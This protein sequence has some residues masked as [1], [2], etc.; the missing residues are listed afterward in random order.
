MSLT[1]FASYR[2]G[3][4]SVVIDSSNVL[5]SFTVADC[6]Y[7]IYGNIDLKGG[8][9]RIPSGC[10][11]DFQ[12]GSMVNGSVVGRETQMN[13][14][15]GN[16]IG[17]TAEGTWSVEKI[18]DSYFDV[19]QLSDNQIMSN[20]NNLQS[21]KIFNKIYLNKDHYCCSIYKAGG[22]VLDVSSNSKVYL[23][24][25]ISIEGNDLVS[26]KIIRIVN[27]E[28]VQIK[29]GTIV[30]D[31]GLHKY[32]DGSTSQWGHGVLIQNSKRVRIEN[33]IVMKCIGDGFT[34][35]GGSGQHTGDMSQASSDV[36]L[37]HVT[38]KF[39]RRQGLSII[40]AENVV[41]KN[42]VFSDTGTIEFQSPS[43][44]IDIEPN[45]EPHNQTTRN[46]KIIN[47]KCERNAGRSILS[48]HYVNYKGV[49]SVSSVVIDGC[50]CDGKV[51]L[52]TG[53]IRIKNSSFAS[54]EVIAEKDP[55]DGLSFTRC[56]I[57][58]QGISLC[59]RNKKNGGETGIDG[60]LFK[61]CRI[62]LPNN[63]TIVNEG[64]PAKLDGNLNNI[65]GV[66][67]NSCKIITNK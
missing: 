28:N 66:V 59:C 56:S 37:N 14:L 4:K 63:M 3:K 40:H 17:F 51:E 47:C 65:M 10:I 61:K 27:R 34:I 62:V 11:L 2:G 31:V 5:S 43:A 35:T 42:S 60:V 24:S 29:G 19:E 38:A 8:T 1:S 45:I 36:V 15:H 55:I 49:K 12:R 20:I 21:D 16:C 48:N 67:F 18:N 13:G 46:I 25:T 39:N 44:G 30:G 57:D 52:Y 9:I 6:H 54:L 22:C 32:V 41:V 23:N 7:I 50:S 58:V 33:T 64:I 26:Y 53:G